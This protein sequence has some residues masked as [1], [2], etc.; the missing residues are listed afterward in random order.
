MGHEM[1]EEVVQSVSDLPVQNPPGEEFSAADLTWAKYASSEHHRDD[2]ALIPYD[3]MEAFIAGESNNPECP[4]RFHIER[5][6]K[7]EEDSLREYRSD[8]YLLYRMYWCSFGPENYGEGGT[9]LPSRRYRLNTRN[10]AARPQSMRGCT[11]HFAVKRLYARPSLL[12]IIYHERRHINKSG[13]ICHGPLDR[14]AIGPGARK[15]PYIGSEIQQQT[16]S[17]IYLGVPEENI[18]QTHIEGIQRYC[19][20]DAR[21]DTHASQYVQKLGMIIK[22]STHELDLDDQA[23][24]RMWVDRNRKSVFFYQDSTETDAF[25]LGIQTEW[26]L[27][28]M[29]RF[30]HQSLLASHS[31]FGVSKLKYPLHTLLVFDSRQHALP[32]AWII[33]RSVTKK[34]TLKWMTALTDRIH[35]IDST[36]RIGGFI[37][38]DPASELTPIRDVFACPV[39]FSLWHIRRTWL[40]N[41]MKKCSNAEVQREIF[42]QLGKIIYSI[43]T[44]KNPMDALGQL[45]QDFIDQT[46]FIKYFKSFWVPKLEMWIESI[47]NLPLASQESCGA[48]EGYHLKLKAKAYDDVQL[49]A[50]QRV[51]WLVHKLTTELHSSYWINLFADES[52]SFPEVKA[53][54]IAST[55]WQR[56]LEIPDDAVIFDDK[57][58]LLAKVVSQKDTSQMWTVWNPGSEFSICDCSWSMQGNLCKHLLKVNMI[59]GMRKDFQPSLSFQSFQHVLLGLW[60]KPLDDS[61]SLDLSVAW[62][63]Q[64][65]EKIQHLAEL[66]T[67]DGIAQVAGKLPI[68]W[69]KRR[70]RR[71]AAKRTSPVVLPHSNGCSQ[72]DL[73]P[74]RSRKRKSLSSFRG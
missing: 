48:I 37:I 70:E 51:D 68:Q 43:W 62:V 36:W 27:Q 59:C 26:Q 33:T 24:I 17:L 60:Q 3:R 5:G 38:D 18:L 12:L 46:T 45:F 39:L 30:G 65:Q 11:C 7:R 52:G 15:V 57:E 32:V 73:T 42:I 47:R 31:S 14:N 55:S 71:R 13:F 16:M 66:V 49:D 23:S 22:R 25:I 74:K 35:S 9:I 2:V 61:F 8:E 6:R 29:M 4:T 64:M 67:S 54:Y 21:V 58:P 44:E 28:Q 34:D 63:M 1:D 72:K 50:L 40:K 10:R 56:A 20:S 19:S 69:T 53:D 41:V